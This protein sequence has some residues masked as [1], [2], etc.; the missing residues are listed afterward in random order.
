M[1]SPM[2]KRIEKMYHPVKKISLD[3]LFINLI[4]TFAGTALYILLI[5]SIF[6]S[7]HGM[8]ILKYL[9]SKI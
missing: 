5:N 2:I 8:S 4:L 3:T 9:L 6:K 7:M 1:R